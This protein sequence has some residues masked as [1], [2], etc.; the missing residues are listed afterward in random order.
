MTIF[1]KIENDKLL[2]EKIIEKA[3]KIGIEKIILNMGRGES[4]E[5]NMHNSNMD[6]F[7]TTFVQSTSITGYIGHKKGSISINVINEKEIENQLDNLK[8]IINSSIDDP[9][10]ELA[11]FEDVKDFESGNLSFSK[12]EMVKR[13]EEFILDSRKKYPIL[14]FE[15][16]I[17]DY[18][19]GYSYLINSNGTKF[20]DK[21]GKFFV[22]ATFSSRI[23]ENVSSFNFINYSK[24]DLSMPILQWEDI[25]LLLRQNTEQ[26]NTKTI[27]DKFEGTLIFTPSSVFD[28]IGFLIDNIK[29][30]EIISGTSIY[31]EK[32]GE[33]VASDILTIEANPLSNEFVTNN[34]FT[35][36]GFLTKPITIVENGVLKTLLL[37]YYGSLKT[38]KPRALNYGS[39]IIIKGDNTPLEK[40]IKSTSKGILLERL[41]GGEVSPN[42]DFSAV[43]KNSYFIKDGN[44]QYPIRETMVSGNFATL[45]KNISGISKESINDGYHIIP[46]IKTEGATISGK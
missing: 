11:P 17:L 3:K 23:D 8:N 34:F 2:A 20:L 22:S 42:G 9:A 29:D 44:I 40:L 25:D 15:E 14:N 7:R 19:R 36:D 10:N 27:N 6:L 12:E 4:H 30:R 21:S 35:S 46:Y 33:L 28:L 18:S 45:L 1:D 31:K 13:F 16:G 26:V 5:L 38:G 41:S 43:A 24:K 37:S 32:V 39:G